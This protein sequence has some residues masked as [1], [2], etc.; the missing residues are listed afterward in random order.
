MISFILAVFAG[1]V[2]MAIGWFAKGF[3]SKKKDSFFRFHR[4]FKVRHSGTQ[5][6]YD[7]FE[8][9]QNRDIWNKLNS[10]FRYLGVSAKTP[11]DNGLLEFMD[12]KKGSGLV[13]R[14]LLMNPMDLD[15]VT[16]QEMHKKGC[17]GTQ[18]RPE[19]K[20]EIEASSKTQQGQ[21]LHYVNLLKRTSPY[22]AG[23][24]KIR[25]TSEFLPWWMYVF[26]GSVLY[27]GLLPFNEDGSKSPLALIMKKSDHFTLFDAFWN[28]WE[29]LWKEAKTMDDLALKK[30]NRQFINCFTLDIHSEPVLVT[31]W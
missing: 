27:L 19:M 14:F 29:R 13:Y 7:S 1:L 15:A 6:Y 30:G 25:F 21:I 20:K 5:G 22:E 10:E 16:R 23:R 8:P 18:P 17:V 31:C 3:F 12:D 24:L 26:N 4:M 2:T 28:N 11:L 9:H